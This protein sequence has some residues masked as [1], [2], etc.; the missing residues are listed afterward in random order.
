LSQRQVFF[1]ADN[2]GEPLYWLV[3]V[4]MKKTDQ[5]NYKNRL[6]IN[7]GKGLLQKST[8][9]TTKANVSVVILRTV[10][11]MMAISCVYRVEAFL[12]FTE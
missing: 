9:T 1:D 4:E 12:V 6:Y 5:A 3:L 10:S 8:S 2:D 7:N 11:I